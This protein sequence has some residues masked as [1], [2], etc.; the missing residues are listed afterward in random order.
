MIVV[1]RCCEADEQ[2]NKLYDKRLNFDDRESRL[3]ISS[4]KIIYSLFLLVFTFILRRN[5]GNEKKIDCWCSNVLVWPR[6][7]GKR[8][9]KIYK[10]DEKTRIFGPDF[11]SN[12]RHLGPVWPPVW[13]NVISRSRFSRIC[14]IFWFLFVCLFVGFQFALS[15]S[16][17][18]LHTP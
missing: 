8:V 10:S 1:A 15:Y 2:R 17:F 9:T 5:S 12:A 11:P 13:I 4:E 16:S 18:C 14:F 6:W 7:N 3:N